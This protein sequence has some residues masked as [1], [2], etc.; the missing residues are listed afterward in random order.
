MKWEMICLVEDMSAGIVVSELLEYKALGMEWRE[1]KWINHSVAY[2]WR[3]NSWQNDVI[4]CLNS[5]FFFFVPTEK[6]LD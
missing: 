4:K 6:H 2:R 3:S 5:L 1:R